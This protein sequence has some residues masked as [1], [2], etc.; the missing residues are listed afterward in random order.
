M[1]YLF[2]QTGKA[3]EEPSFEPD[4]AEAD[5][6]EPADEEEDT[7]EGF[8]DVEDGTIPLL[9]ELSILPSAPTASKPSTSAEL[10]RKPRATRRR[11]SP[12]TSVPVPG[13]RSPQPG[14]STRQ[15]P[16]PSPPAPSSPLLVKPPLVPSDEDTEVSIFPSS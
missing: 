1:E 15:S 11:S 4:N 9:P 6:V 12:R 7:D 2:S 5:T 16:P 8:Q 10:A 13:Q 14:P 3:F